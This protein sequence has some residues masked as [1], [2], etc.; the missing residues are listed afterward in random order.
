ME[1]FTILIPYGILLYTSGRSAYLPR[2]VITY[3]CSKYRY[4]LLARRAAII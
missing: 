1:L 3:L 4:L 2:E